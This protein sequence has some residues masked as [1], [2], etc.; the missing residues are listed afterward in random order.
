MLWYQMADLEAQKDLPDA[1]REASLESPH[2]EI[3]RGIRS[4]GRTWA[5]VHAKVHAAIHVAKRGGD[6]DDYLS[7][8]PRRQTL[9][10]ADPRGRAA[11]A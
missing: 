5:P 4:V 9:C 8:H 10:P 1:D 2:E 6:G 7:V 3:S 11:E